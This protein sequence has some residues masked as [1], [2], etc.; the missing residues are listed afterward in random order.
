MEKA[1]DRWKQL[2]E[3]VKSE[4]ERIDKAQESAFEELSVRLSERTSAA[5]DST[6]SAI[7]ETVTVLGEKIREQIQRESEGI[8]RSVE[9][10]MA[11]ASGRQSQALALWSKTATLLIVWS[12][13]VG[14][15]G[16]ATWHLGA[17]SAQTWKEL[18][19]LE[20]A[21]ETENQALVLMRQHGVAYQTNEQGLWIQVEASVT[22]QPGSDGRTQWILLAR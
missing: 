17:R 21:Y 15:L 16:L 2:E 7:D 3:R 12:A 9:E 14:V 5:L 1:S 11:K 10:A 13:L 19:L 4:S 20:G 18:R 6:E 8:T 22:P